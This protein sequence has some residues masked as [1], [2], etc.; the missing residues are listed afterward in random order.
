M[1]CY[2]L[3]TDDLALAVP[4]SLRW[5]LIDEV[6]LA[7]LA[8]WRETPECQ[9]TFDNILWLQRCLKRLLELADMQRGCQDYDLDSPLAHRLCH[10]QNEH[11]G[12]SDTAN[13]KGGSV[14]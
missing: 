5:T 4:I 1:E 3:R 12:D 14:P 9:L 13:E 6:E 7:L 10:A 11:G 2:V 8:L